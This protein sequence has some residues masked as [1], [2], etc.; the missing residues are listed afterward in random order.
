MKVTHKKHDVSIYTQNTT[1]F[2]NKSLRAFG[3]NRWNTLPEYIK[4]T[5]SLLEL[6]N[7]LKHG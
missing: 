1:K 2:G 4:S 6:K 3:P 7:S 5:T